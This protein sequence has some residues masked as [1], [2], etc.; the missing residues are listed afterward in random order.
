MRLEVKKN[1]F[2]KR[3][4]LVYLLACMPI[5]LLGMIAILPPAAR[6]WLDFT[7]YP[8][9]FSGIYSALILRTV[10]FF[11]CAWIFM[12]LF[13]GEMVDRSLHYYFLSAVRRDVL[14]AGKYFSGL[15]T[16]IL[17]FTGLTIVSM[18]LFFLPHFYSASVRFFL[19]GPGLSQLSTYAAITILACVGYGAF[20]LVVG[21]FVRNPILPALLLYCWE[22][23]NFLLPPLLKKISVI[24]YLNSL[25]PVPLSE[26][27]FAVVAEPT[28]AWISVPGLLVVTALV[29]F[30][31]SRRIQRMEIRYGSE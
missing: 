1:F 18:L 28:P 27:P 29:L 11:G 26:G 19:D 16:S 15:V 12:N 7:A 31:A 21:L 22:W 13:R 3:A 24:H 8:K 17:L 23:I 9:L 2:G 14:I 6:E 5:G 10:V 4:F 25:V 20:F 30:V